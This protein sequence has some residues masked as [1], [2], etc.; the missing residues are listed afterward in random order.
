MTPQLQM[1]LAQAVKPGGCLRWPGAI[2]R[3]GYGVVG[4]DG[5]Q[6]R[7][8]RVVYASVHGPIPPDLLVC[9]KCDYPRCV[10]LEHLF[11]GTLL[12]NAKDCVAKGRHPSTKKRKCPKGHAYTVENTYVYAT[13]RRC[14]ACV[15]KRAKAY[16]RKNK[17]QLNAKAL[18]RYY[19]REGKWAYLKEAN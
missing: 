4:L 13:G 17:V 7:V 6:H 10:R 12:D 11:L 19:N 14:K 18:K 3:D 5:K 1:V 16:W 9:H 8:H 2:D 15:L